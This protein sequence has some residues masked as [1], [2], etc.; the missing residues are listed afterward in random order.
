MWVTPVATQEPLTRCVYHNMLENIYREGSQVTAA[1]FVMTEQCNLRCKYCYEEHGTKRMTKEVAFAGVDFLMRQRTN[2]TSIT[3]FGGEPTLEADLICDTIDYAIEENKKHDKNLHFGMVTNCTAL[4]V[5]LEE[6]ILEVAQDYQFDVQLSI[7]GPEEVQDMYRVRP[8]GSGS[9]R[10]VD[11]TLNKWKELAENCSQLNLSVH[12]CLNKHSLGKLFESFLYFRVDRGIQ[13]LWYIPVSEEDWTPEDVDIYRRELK[14]IQEWIIEQCE[15]DG[16]TGEVNNY[17]PLDR[18]LSSVTKRGAP[19]AAGDN[20][21]SITP[22][23]ALSPCHQ[24]HFNNPDSACGDV[25]MGVDNEAR[26]FYT[27]YDDDDF[28]YCSDCDHLHCYRCIAHNFD[29][30]GC[31]LTPRGGS[32]CDMMLVDKELQDELKEYVERKENG[33]A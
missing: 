11:P 18:C 26:R 16:H 6:K 17:A 5:Q 23:G 4:P 30:R 32:Y 21:L 3:F 12:G 33:F 7:D 31:P 20:F 1:Y 9:W 2:Q 10:F 19:C 24:M 25:W 29:S 27:E 22:E 8:D 15:R 14:K 28:E 13:R